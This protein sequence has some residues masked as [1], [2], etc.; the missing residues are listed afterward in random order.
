MPLAQ[1][2]SENGLN[3]DEANA[4]P[5][6]ESGIWWTFAK[7]NSPLVAVLAATSIGEEGTW[8]AFFLKLA[9]LGTLPSLAILFAAFV[10][11]YRLYSVPKKGAPFGGSGTQGKQVCDGE[12]VVRL[13]ATSYLARQMLIWS[14]SPVARVGALVVDSCARSGSTLTLAILW[15]VVAAAWVY[16]AAAIAVASGSLSADTACFVANIT[17]ELG[18]FLDSICCDERPC[19]SAMYA[20]LSGISMG[21]LFVPHSIVA[22]TTAATRKQ[23]FSCFL[24]TS[25]YVAGS[26]KVATLIGAQAGLLAVTTAVFPVFLVSLL[27]GNFALRFLPPSAYAISKRMEDKEWKLLLTTVLHRGIGQTVLGINDAGLERGLDSLSS[28]D[29]KRWTPLVASLVRGQAVR[30]NLVGDVKLKMVVGMFHQDW[31]TGIGFPT[32]LKRNGDIIEPVYQGSSSSGDFK[33]AG[34]PRR[35]VQVGIYSKA[36][37]NSTNPILGNVDILPIFYEQEDSFGN[38][39]PPLSILCV[40]PFRHVRCRTRRQTGS[41]Y[42]KSVGPPPVTLEEALLVLFSAQLV[43]WQCLRWLNCGGVG[44]EPPAWAT[45]FVFCM[46]NA[47]GFQRFEY[48]WLY[49]AFPLS[50]KHFI[51][52]NDQMITLLW[53]VLAIC[54]F[55]VRECCKTPLYFVMFG[56][57]VALAEVRWREWSN[58]KRDPC[59]RWGVE[60]GCTEDATTLQKGCGHQ[61]EGVARLENNPGVPVGMFRAT[62][63]G[64]PD[65]RDSAVWDKDSSTG[66]RACD[67]LSRR[68]IT[69]A[70]ALSA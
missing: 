27:W 55:Q 46:F 4:A 17:G 52:Q 1:A 70:R 29:R 7:W 33:K 60:G 26:C 23:A 51:T 65:N 67:E 22:F 62:A 31:H 10:K 2:M 6:G 14:D 63:V 30:K 61:K 3:T 15:S 40:Q 21:L 12:D 45:A 34:V 35:L 69:P 66:L 16:V 19:K 68:I 64:P 53:I 44:G 49:R 43:C 56:Y 58:W 38:N 57:V 13:G 11:H 59:W 18:Q 20:A 5:S 50:V 28:P 48:L 24:T 42:C 9:K 37:T 25:I 47:P 39:M 36:G 41:G 32:D 54:I 8:S